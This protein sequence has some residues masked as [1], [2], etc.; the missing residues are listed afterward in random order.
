[1]GL[2]GTIFF[3]VCVE[4]ATRQGIS[5]GPSALL[6]AMSRGSGYLDACKARCS[7]VGA[8]GVEQDAKV[9]SR[10]WKGHK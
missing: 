3:S 4:E 10:V 2:Q 5:G 1:M 9:E 7:A 8:V 6:G